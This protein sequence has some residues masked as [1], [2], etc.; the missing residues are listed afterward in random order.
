MLDRNVI[1]LAQRNIAEVL[2]FDSNFA[3]R[4]DGGL[5]V[6]LGS[7]KRSAE[8]YQLAIA[9]MAKRTGSAP[10]IVME[11]EIAKSIEFA[12]PAVMDDIISHL[13]QINPEAFA[14]AVFGSKRQIA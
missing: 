14:L 4:E 5:T 1:T 6:Y 3:R 8:Q 11:G 2:G 9:C 13:A 10:R 12:A 7:I